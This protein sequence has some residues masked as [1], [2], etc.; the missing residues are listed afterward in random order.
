MYSG[1]K[2]SGRVYKCWEKYT[3]ELLNWSRCTCRGQVICHVRPNNKEGF[4]MLREN[5]CPIKNDKWEK[6]VPPELCKLDWINS[7][8][9]IVIY[10]PLRRIN[11]VIMIH[12]Y[13]YIWPWLEVILHYY[14][15]EEWDWVP[16]N[17]YG[18]IHSEVTHYVGIYPQSIFLLF[19]CY[20]PVDWNC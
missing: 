14:A 12:Y 10:M 17:W 2:F 8:I 16:S 19:G 5:T 13:L 4:G 20:T 1:P 3:P 18:R 7:T 9:M 11:F 15:D 6:T